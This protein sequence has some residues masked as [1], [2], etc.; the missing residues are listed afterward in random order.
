MI[1]NISW[2]TDFASC[3]FCKELSGQQTIFHQLTGNRL[4]D[5][6]VL[7]TDNFVV[8]PSLGPIAQGH[9][10][11]L[12]CKHLPN[13]L[14]IEREV[15][16]EMTELRDRC[17]S[18]LK[19]TFDT[20]VIGFEHGPVANSGRAGSCIDH[21]HL[22]LITTNINYLDT[23][24][25]FFNWI[26]ITDDKSVT[27]TIVARA[28][29]YVYYMGPDGREFVATAPPSMPS[30]FSR[31]IIFETESKVGH[32]NWRLFPNPDAVIS[33]YND[34]VNTFDSNID[35][36]CNVRINTISLNK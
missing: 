8:W 30:Q 3:T 15:Y 25:K 31:R 36:T 17:V 1:D 26:E 28:L 24:A 27:Q 35:S 7:S 11:L 29:P 33:M 10:M 20:N 12:S 4:Q 18:L 13:L 23:L 21:A 34:L 9:I 2:N 32:W 5:R 19:M 16:P 14:S 6:T 22:H